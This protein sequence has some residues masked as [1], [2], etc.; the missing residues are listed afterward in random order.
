MLHRPFAKVAVMYP[1]IDFPRNNRISNGDGR[2]DVWYVTRGGGKLI[3]GNDDQTGGTP[4]PEILRTFA[5]RIS[6]RI[7]VF[8]VNPDAGYFRFGR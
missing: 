1:V 5:L 2:V 6:K 7:V 3:K 8:D 4:M